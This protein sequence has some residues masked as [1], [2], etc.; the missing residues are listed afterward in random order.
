MPNRLLAF[1]LLAVT[2]VAAPALAHEYKLGDLVIDQP[3]ARASAGNAKSGA[4]Y[5]AIANHGSGPDRL[6]GASSPAGQAELHNNV[7]EDGIMK[8]RPVEAVDLAPGETVVLEP[9]GLHL[10]LMGLA[11]PLVEG[12]TFPLTLTFEKAGSIHVE[13][14]VE[15]VASM[16]GDHDDMTGD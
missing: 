11:E 7:S 6:I 15:G 5:L 3:W 10:M 16:H 1:L 14:K 12:K 2:A 9:G 4:A 13:V 8:M